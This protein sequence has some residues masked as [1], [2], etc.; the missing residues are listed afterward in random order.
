[1]GGSLRDLELRQE[2]GAE[3]KGV[4]GEEERKVGGGGG[5]ATGRRVFRCIYNSSIS[6]NFLV[7]IYL[8]LFK[9]RFES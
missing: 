3:E 6:R 8:C 2:S 5:D 9:E 7:V 4:R 1:M